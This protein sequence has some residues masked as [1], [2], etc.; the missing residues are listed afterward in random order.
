M[1]K[2][3]ISTVSAKVE[4]TKERKETRDRIEEERH[5]QI[6]VR[7]TISLVVSRVL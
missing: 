7:L 2:I 4:T 1:Q 5:H 6:E 3:K